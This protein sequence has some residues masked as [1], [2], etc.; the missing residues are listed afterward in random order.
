MIRRTMVLGIL[1]LTGVASTAHARCPTGLFH[2]DLKTC[3]TQGLANNVTPIS[4]GAAAVTASC[5]AAAWKQAVYRIALVVTPSPTGWA[6]APG[7]AGTRERPPPSRKAVVAPSLARLLE[8]A[9]Y[10]RP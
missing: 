5:P 10:P 8:P 6:F 4:C 3:A 2:V 7:C 9:P 1:V